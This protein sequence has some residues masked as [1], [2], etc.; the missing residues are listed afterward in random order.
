MANTHHPSEID[1]ASAS[2]AAARDHGAR[3]KRV[4][5]VLLAVL[6]AGLLMWP[7][8]RPVPVILAQ[9][10]PLTPTFTPTASGT[11]TPTPTPT[12]SLSPTP[13]PTKVKRVVNEIRSPSSGDAVARSVQIIGTAL[14]DNFSRYDI[15][16]SPAGME[17]WTWLRTNIEVVHDDALLLLDTTAYP[18]GLYDIRV[19]AIDIFGSYTESY[20]RNIE[21]RN[22]NPPTPTPLPGAT[23]PAVSPL[24]LPT[25]TPTP[26][27]RRLGPGGQGF[28]APDAGSV[29]RGMVDIVATVNGFPDNPFERYELY[30]ARA[31]RVDWQWLAG[32]EQQIWQGPIYQWD[33]TQ[34][35]DGLYDLRL[36]IVLKDSNYN[37]FFLRNMSIANH[38]RPI[39]A[40]S[41]QVGITSPRGGDNVRGVVEF[42]GIVPSEE[43]LRWELYWSPGTKEEWQFLVSSSEPASGGVLARV[44]L[45][46]L[47]SGLYDFRLRIVRNDTNYT[48]TY[49]RG[50]R[51]L[52]AP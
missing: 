28:Y 44:D 8:L 42:R 46:Q 3:V 15:H 36:R 14:I 39:L 50:L 6:V 13:T 48:D 47:P 22:S 31:G 30:V 5:L 45:S 52:P 4:G 26:D 34:Y 23:S 21:I 41:P 12:L 27:E 29:V 40:L 20:L 33:T 10:S 38:S 2:P 18:D 25:P 32:G 11:P 7:D 49:A 19:R 17:S 16:I 35:E 37:E 51:L 43:L 24:D 1:S 9:Q